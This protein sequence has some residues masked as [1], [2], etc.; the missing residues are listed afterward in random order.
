MLPC[1]FKYICY[2]YWEVRSFEREHGFQGKVPVCLIFRVLLAFVY[3][4]LCILTTQ[5]PHSRCLYLLAIQAPPQ[6]TQGSCFVNRSCSQIPLLE[7]ELSAF[8][9]GFWFRFVVISYFS[10][11]SLSHQCIFIANCFTPLSDTLRTQRLGQYSVSTHCS[12]VYV[13]AKPALVLDQENIREGNVT[14]R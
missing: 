4:F 2:E 7:G 5:H 6:N 9:L 10:L 11:R 14:P 8:C 1:D 12:T 3:S 13:F